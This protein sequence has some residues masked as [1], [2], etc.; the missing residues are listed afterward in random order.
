[1]FL[2]PYKKISWRQNILDRQNER[3]TWS[4]ACPSPNRS[5][6]HEANDRATRPDSTQ[7][8]RSNRQDF[9]ASIVSREMFYERKVR[10]RDEGEELFSCKY[11]FSRLSNK[12]FFDEMER[13]KCQLK[14][15][16]AGIA[17]SLN[18]VIVPSQ[19][20]FSYL[21][22]LYFIAATICR[23][24]IQHDNLM[25]QRLHS[26]HAMPRIKG[27]Q[28][29]LTWFD[30]NKHFQPRVMHD[31]KTLTLASIA[32]GA[33]RERILVE[34]SFKEVYFRCVQSTRLPEEYARHAYATLNSSFH[35]A[36]LRPGP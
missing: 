34:H 21:R 16:L 23:I 13:G 11:F 3:V 28:V 36:Y 2:M 20:S 4:P 10:C 33:K 31:S 35:S 5:L 30:F 9:S 22:K 15:L 7:F 29:N 25:V 17:S 19:S 18:L 6:T 27:K 12:T 24:K 32:P 14:H 26:C 8:L 1:M